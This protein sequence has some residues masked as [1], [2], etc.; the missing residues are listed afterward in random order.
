MI[1]AENLVVPHQMGWCTVLIGDTNAYKHVDF[2]F[3]NIYDALE[4]ITPL[5]S[6][7]FIN[8]NYKVTF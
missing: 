3:S 1:Y 5:L 2:C 8:K 7:N 4:G 6:S